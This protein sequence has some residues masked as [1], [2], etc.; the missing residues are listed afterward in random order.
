MSSESLPFSEPRQK[1]FLGHIIS[2]K[3]YYLQV[4]DKV[5]KN[6]FK[7][8]WAGEAY[9][10]YLKWSEIY[11]PHRDKI[12]TVEEVQNSAAFMALKPDAANK[13]RAVIQQ[14]LAAKATFDWDAIVG[15][16]SKWLKCRIY[17]ENITKSTDLFN[18]GNFEEAFKILDKNT[19][20][21][22]NIKFFPDD[23]HDF[24][25]WR[26]H[27]TQAEQQY[28]NALTTGLTLLDR[29]I[30]PNSPAGCLLPGD[31]TILL[32]PSNLGKCHGKGTKIIDFNGNIV[33][34]ENI[35]TGDLLMGPDGTPRKV[36]STTQG[37]GPLYRV[38]PKVGGDSFVCNDV[39]VLSLKCSND[40]APEN[41]K[42]AKN[43]TNTPNK[44]KTMWKGDI[45]NIP[46][47]EY[48]QKSKTWKNRTKLW[49]SKLDFSHKDLPM[50]P[51][52]LGLWLG[53]GHSQ[54]A[55]LTSMDSVLSDI[56]TKW[57]ESNGDKIAVYNQNNNKAYTYAARASVKHHRVVS[58]EIL[59]LIGVLNNKHIPH[60][61]L[62]SSRDQRLSLLAGLIDTDGYYSKEGKNFEITQKSKTLMDNIVFLSRSLGFKVTVNK[63]KKIDQNGTE[64][65]YQRAV[66]L[67]ALSEIPT[68]LE[69]K[70]GQDGLKA[71]DTTGFRV[72]AIGTGD[73]YG[74]TLDKDH[75]YML[76]DFT[77]THNTTCMI[78]MMAANL[79]L[80][81][82]VLF[83]T[84]EGRKDD[85]VDKIWSNITGKPKDEL[86]RLYKTDEKL[87][88]GA[89]Y[90]FK[91]Y[92]TYMHIVDPA[93]MTV[94]HVASVIERK[95]QEAINKDGKGFDLLVV[96]YPAKLTTDYSARVNM[97]FRQ[98]EHYVYNYFVQLGLKHK[99][100]VLGAIQANREASKNNKFQGEYGTH[101]RLVT[102]EDVSE[103][104]GPMTVATNV[105]SI[106]RNDSYGNKVIYHLCKSRS[107]ETGWSVLA[108]SDYSKAIVHS[109]ELGGLVY[110]GNTSVVKIDDGV[111]EQYLGK[112]L[113][114]EKVLELDV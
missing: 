110:K 9:G 91:K 12:P 101:N 68:K 1:A 26:T 56:W 3:T 32:A 28:N 64:G 50:D 63:C 109:N 107:S 53:D 93:L 100:H 15:E 58:T 5:K 40:K 51:Y 42:R 70:K 7:D 20:D 104:W 25:D 62:T 43:T 23:E 103:S 45:V 90:F 55:S 38:T 106:N 21:Y 98:S 30:E 86:R 77:V 114:M 4:K 46:L 24:S 88:T 19:N 105:L 73:Y 34:V 80:L 79:K 16:L 85:I 89:S 37:R 18:G 83:I 52:V 27:F 33:K 57:V 99:F 112:T 96:D 29:I 102:M 47:N 36:L 31:T 69:R 60:E 48:L 13:V 22:Q 66:I 8:P 92:L 95:Q 113:P 94:E 65:L 6:W 108:K 59:N 35:K 54:S 10:L 17:L 41:R 81:K 111:L 78:T 76:G 74:F 39:H 75:L 71:W 11:D 87:F 97:Q 72:K 2:N 44:E 14:S 82:K 61:Y 84:H 67:G 49:R